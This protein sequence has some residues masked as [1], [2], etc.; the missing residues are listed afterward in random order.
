MEIFRIPIETPMRDNTILRGDLYTDDPSKTRQRPVLLQRTCY[1]RNMASYVTAAEA[2][3]RHGYWTVV[4]ETRGRNDSEGEWTAHEQEAED[5]YDTIEWLATQPFSNGAIGT[6]GGSYSGWLQL[7]A[8]HLRPPSLKAMVVTSSHLQLMQAFGRDRNFRQPR[9]LTWVYKMSHRN[10]KPVGDVDW[11]SIL[12]T[13]PLADASKE[14]PSSEPMWSRWMSEEQLVN[15]DPVQSGTDVKIHIPTLHISGWEDEP[16]QSDVYMRAVQN[17]SPNQFMM[18]GPW[19]HPGTRTPVRETRGRDFGEDAVVPMHEVY[20]S[21]FDRWMRSDQGAVGS[22]NHVAVFMSGLNRWVAYPE[23]PASNA[24]TVEFGFNSNADKTQNLVSADTEMFGQLTVRH[25]PASPVQAFG[26]LAYSDTKT[27]NSLIA[28]DENPDVAKLTSA[29][30]P[31]AL[32]VSGRI[33]VSMSTTSTA[34]KA[35]W[36]LW[37]AEVGSDGVPIR[38]TSNGQRATY[39]TNQSQQVQVELGP[40]CYQFQKGSRIRL[41]LAGSNFPVWD[42][43]GWHDST[44]GKPEVTTNTVLSGAVCMEVDGALNTV[45]LKGKPMAWTH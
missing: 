35:D 24:P 23:W 4:Q 42:V 44:D 40:V 22:R 32:N 10:M 20:A 26:T 19:D 41:Y 34:D 28:L 14:L 36:C 29:A 21:W 3:A 12:R 17:E 2:L 9:A 30:I 13:R 1:D 7:A 6:L 39:G 8:E 15:S 5:G 33:T 25:D 11:D 31:S 18:V 16:G 37:L 38:V 45:N 27:A 43:L